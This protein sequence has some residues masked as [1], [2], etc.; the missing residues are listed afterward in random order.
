MAD[1]AE[2]LR[3]AGLAKLPLFSADK[4][5]IFTCE[6]WISRV[7][8]AKDLSGWN[9]ARTM[10]CVINTLR[11]SAFAYTR[12]INLAADV[13]IVN[14]DSFKV[15]QPPSTS[16]PLFKAKQNVSSTITSGLPIPL[17]TWP[18][19]RNSINKG[20]R[21]IPLVPSWGLYLRSSP[22]TSPSVP[23]SPSTSSTLVSRIVTIDNIALHLFVSGL[24][25]NIRDEVMRQSPITLTEAKAFASD[26]EKRA[27]I[28]Q[29]KTSGATSLP[30]MPVE[31]NNSADNAETEAELVAALEE[32][33]KSQDCKI[34][35]LKAK[36]N[37]FRRNN[38][39][40]GSS[41]SGPSTS[42]PRPP[43]KAPNPAAKNIDCHYCGRIGH[44]QLNCRD[45]K[46]AGAPMVGSNS[47]PYSQRPSA[48]VDS[49]GQAPTNTAALF[50]SAPP[51]A[52]GPGQ[53]VYHPNPYTNS[54]LGYYQST[55]SGFQ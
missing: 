17:T 32:T 51:L 48:A 20:S 24:K 28:P 11:G 40:S 47:V 54:N 43:K 12:S 34:A 8:C 50:A 9:N 3:Q 7:Q 25:P 21:Q 30:M 10:T 15:A 16:P 23:R 33:E 44:F 2:D 41:S 49:N 42:A 6:Q 27:T 1:H 26:A 53:V 55:P 4:T 14:W 29:S 13:D 18:P 31:D 52:A 36:I 45:R 38:Q 5:D 46:R 22:P 35:V 37:R 19:S 39:S